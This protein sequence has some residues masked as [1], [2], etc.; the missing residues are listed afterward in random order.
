MVTKA[1]E[2]MAPKYTFFRKYFEIGDEE[3][4]IH[5]KSVFFV[6]SVKKHYFYS[7]SMVHDSSPI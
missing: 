5:K 1:D 4:K 2:E 7:P 6:S 3:I